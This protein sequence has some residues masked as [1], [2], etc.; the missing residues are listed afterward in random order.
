MSIE[1]TFV[2]LVDKLR[3]ERKRMNQTVIFCRIYDQCSRIYMFMVDKLGT[4]M[5]EPVAISRDLPQFRLLDMFT[6][7]TRPVVT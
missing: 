3:Q 7:C 4:E 5:T 1:E 6:A 2:P